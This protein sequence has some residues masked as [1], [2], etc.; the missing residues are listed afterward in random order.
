[1]LVRRFKR[2]QFAV[3]GSSAHPRRPP[4]SDKDAVR[5][6]KE[7]NGLTDEQHR[8]W[9]RDSSRQ[10]TPKPDSDLRTL[11]AIEEESLAAWLMGSIVL[12][13]PPGLLVCTHTHVMRVVMLDF[14]GYLEEIVIAIIPPE[15]RMPR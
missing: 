12:P 10:W 13:G 9:I 8:L 7:A 14:L 15:V 6:A 3:M 4:S 2:H 11:V 5:Q 1:M